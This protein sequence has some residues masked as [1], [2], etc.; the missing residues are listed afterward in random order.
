LTAFT[1]LTVPEEL[2]LDTY[3]QT[4]ETID[5]SFYVRTQESKGISLSKHYKPEI[6]QVSTTS[7]ARTEPGKSTSIDDLD[8]FMALF[9]AK[10]SPAAVL[11]TVIAAH[12]GG[13]LRSMASVKQH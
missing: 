2:M 13:K 10:S 6:E 1:L 3:L 7:P 4:Y 12:D 11:E 8:K 5:R 9:T